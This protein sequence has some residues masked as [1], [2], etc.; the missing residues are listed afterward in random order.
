LLNGAVEFAVSRTNNVPEFSFAT[1]SESEICDAVM[2]TFVIHKI[3]FAC[4]HIFVSSEF[5]EKWKTSAVLPIPK[6]SSL[7]KFSDYR[8][9]SLLVC[10]SIVFEV[11]MA[12]Q[13]ER[14]IH[15]NNLLTVLQ[16]GFRRHHSTAAVVLRV[17]EDI[18]LN[19]EDGKVTVLVLL[20]FSQAFDMVVHG[21]LLCKLRNAQNY[22]VGAGLLVALYLSERTQFVR[23]GGQE[24]SVGT[25]GFHRD[26][27]FV[28]SCLYHILTT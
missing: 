11:L 18:R 2:S 13:M 17:T 10:L 25:V 21:M 9:I 6:V 3:A 8:P 4:N 23:S 15:C 16:S 12:R 28:R 1:V 20:D 19:M 27:F 26:L 7:A 14:H 5:P 24:S 22:W